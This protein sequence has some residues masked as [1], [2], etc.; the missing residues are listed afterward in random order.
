MVF[1]T[2]PPVRSGG[3]YNVFDEAVQRIEARFKPTTSVSLN[4]F[5][6]YT[7]CQEEGECFDNFLTALRA[8]SVHCNFGMMTD[9]MIRDQIIVHVKSKK[10]QEQLWIF[11][12]PSLEIAITV[13]KKGIPKNH[14]DLGVKRYR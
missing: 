14:W 2:L 3:D 13:R 9:E 4:R 10:T 1:R 5:K 12:D 7:R 8:L 11:G 6:F